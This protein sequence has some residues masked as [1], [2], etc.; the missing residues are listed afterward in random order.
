MITAIDFFNFFTFDNFFIKF[1]KS[2]FLLKGALKNKTSKCS[3]LKFIFVKSFFF[4]VIFVL[5]SK[6]FLQYLYCASKNSMP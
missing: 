4:I 2:L 3:F 6:I 5:F 1:K